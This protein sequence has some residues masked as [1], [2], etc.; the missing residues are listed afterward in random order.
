MN[1]ST[2]TAMSVTSAGKQPPLFF[3]IGFTQWGQVLA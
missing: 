2:P 1:A 3:G